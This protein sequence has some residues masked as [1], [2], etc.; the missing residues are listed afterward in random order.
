MATLAPPGLAARSAALNKLYGLPAPKAKPAPETP[1]ER[2]LRLR[3]EAENKRYG[4]P[5]TA[6]DT[7]GTKTIGPGAPPAA[8]GIHVPGYD[9]DYA[10]LI[11]GDPT[12]LSGEADLTDYGNSVDTA[13]T[14]AIRRAVVAS[15]FNPGVANSDVDQATI[16][17]ALANQGSTA[18]LIEEERQHRS[19]DLEALLAARG[20]LDSGA[21]TGGH[22]RVQTN[23]E[24]AQSS[25]VQQLLDSITGYEG[26]AATKHADISRQHAALREAAALR[27]QQDPRFQPV[28]EADAVLDPSTGLYMTPDGRWYNADGTRA[29]APGTGPADTGA[30]APPPV[31]PTQGPPRNGGRAARDEYYLDPLNMY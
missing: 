5:N 13:K 14:A 3:S 26:D 24:R 10:K 7:G 18:K 4:L 27:V 11:A 23:Y 6:V 16:D 2:A 28:G 31:A 25:A 21:L 17:A 30:A 22:Q 20:M 12:L 15:G 19:T 29:T 9:P 8:Q 1:W